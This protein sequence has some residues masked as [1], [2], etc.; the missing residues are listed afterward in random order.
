MRSKNKNILRI[1]WR[2]P[3]PAETMHVCITV[4]SSGWLNGHLLLELQWSHTVPKSKP[5]PSL[6][7]GV[8]QAIKCSVVL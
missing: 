2:V 8:V 6:F 4:N 5:L 3:L 7:F 1:I